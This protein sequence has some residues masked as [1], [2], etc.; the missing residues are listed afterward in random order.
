[1]SFLF[2][3]PACL[4]TKG[5]ETRVKMTPHPEKRFKTGRQIWGWA[6]KADEIWELISWQ[7]WS[8]ASFRFRNT[9]FSHGGCH[10]APS[11]HMTA[12][13]SAMLWS[14]QSASLSHRLPPST[15][16]SPSRISMEVGGG[17]NEVNFCPLKVFNLRT[18]IVLTF[19][20]RT[21]AQCHGI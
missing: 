21:T 10:A 15:S 20:S 16:L 13:C 19:L 17:E 9:K 2:H 18:Y 8:P 4:P 12:L 11:E 7:R 5:N 14:R 1:M 3:L 6:G